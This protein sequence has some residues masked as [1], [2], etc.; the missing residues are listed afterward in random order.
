VNQ[1][2]EKMNIVPIPTTEKTQLLR[3]TYKFTPQHGNPWEWRSQILKDAVVRGYEFNH[4]YIT[5]NKKIKD[6]S[7]LYNTKLK[8]VF[9]ITN[10]KL[11][12]TDL[13]KMVE[14][15]TDK[16]LHLPLISEGFVKKYA[17]LQ[18]NIDEVMVDMIEVDDREKSTD[19]PDWI[20][21]V[22]VDK[23]NYITITKVEKTW[24]DIQ[25]D[26]EIRF[27]YQELVFDWLKNNYSVPKKLIK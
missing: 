15:T 9:Y 2:K 13:N 10:S 25:N 19:C 26:F 11:V 20:K 6:N 8:Q 17:E 5:S 16:S 1:L 24:D 7:W 18:G 3:N 22:K 14:A 27:P 4:L 23:N 12:R 21:I